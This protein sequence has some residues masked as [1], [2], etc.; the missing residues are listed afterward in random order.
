MDTLKVIKDLEHC[1]NADCRECGHAQT[2]S[3]ITCGRLLKA[4]LVKVRK[5]AVY[6]RLLKKG[7]MMKLPCAVGDKIY[8]I[9]DEDCEGNK[10][11]TVMAERVKFIVVCKDGFYTSCADEVMQDFDRIG[12]RW[13]LLTR[14]EAEK[15]AER[16]NADI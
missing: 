11:K 9:S 1:L 2:E 13:A 7:K 15:M 4:V 6:E 16:M 14:K 8:W 12:S 10:V 5:L 3:G